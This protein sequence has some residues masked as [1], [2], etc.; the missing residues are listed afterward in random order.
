M[1]RDLRGPKHANRPIAVTAVFEQACAA[2]ERPGW[3]PDAL[4]PFCSRF[5]E[6]DG[7]RIHYVDEGQRPPLL[8]LHENPACLT[9]FQQLFPNRETIELI[10]CG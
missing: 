4:F 2:I 6:I 5:I 1:L 10:G 9:R 7:A 3:L 8:C